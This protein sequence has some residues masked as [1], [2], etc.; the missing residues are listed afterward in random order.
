MIVADL[1]NPDSFAN[2]LNSWLPELRDKCP[3]AVRLLAGNKLDCL[4]GEVSPKI[5][6][7]VEAA[8]AQGL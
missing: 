8:R 4:E 2:A 7:R 5:R 3:G 1:T 6:E